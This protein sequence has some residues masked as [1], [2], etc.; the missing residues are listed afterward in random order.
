MDDTI[1]YDDIKGMLDIPPTLAPRPNFFRLRSFR[2]YIVDVI[3]QIP[4]PGNPQHGWAGMVLQ[5][6]IFALINATP[7]ATPPNPGLYAVYP[8]FAQPAAI[9]LINNQF[10]INRNLHKRYTNVH[11]AVYKLLQDNVLPQYQA[12][13]TP[14]LTGWDATMSI[15]DIF[16]QL[17]AMFGKPDTQAQLLNNSN[18]Y[19]PLL[20]METPETLF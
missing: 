18:F 17:D 1:L 16:A 8:Q 11:C 7:F 3:K 20:P 13:A 12:S 2:Q 4:H 9:K 10:K 6:A 14:G 19:V 15:I 5:P